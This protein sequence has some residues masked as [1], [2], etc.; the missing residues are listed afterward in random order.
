MYGPWIESFRTLYAEF[1][2]N[3]RIAK[4]RGFIV[5]DIDYETIRSVLVERLAMPKLHN[6]L[7]ADKNAILEEIDNLCAL[8]GRVEIVRTNAL[9]RKQRLLWEATYGRFWIDKISYREELC[10]YI[11]IYWKPILGPLVAKRKKIRERSR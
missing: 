9:T 7:T 5:S 8:L 3:E 11:E 4:V 6:S 1:W 2:Q 10:E